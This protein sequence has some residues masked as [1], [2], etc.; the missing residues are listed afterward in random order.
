MR[1]GEVSPRSSLW[2]S[3]RFSLRSSCSAYRGRAGAC[4]TARGSCRVWCARV[5]EED[6]DR[7]AV[8][9]ALRDVGAVRFDRSRRKKELFGDLAVLQALTDQIEDL[10]LEGL[11]GMWR[12]R[13]LQTSRR[14]ASRAALIFTRRSSGSTGFSMKEIAPFSMASTAVRIVPWPES[15][16]TA[17]GAVEI[18]KAL[19]NLDAAHAGHGQVDDEA[20]GLVRFDEVEEVFAAGV[21]ACIDAVRRKSKA[22]R[23]ADLVVVD[24]PD[25]DFLL[26]QVF[27]HGLLFGTISDGHISINIA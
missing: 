15:T 11:A 16:M 6:A 2:P 19:Q 9:K 17:D 10:C 4:R 27:L 24:D 21:G 14:E 23:I 12:T 3:S 1:Q 18:A 7:R 25:G 8:F 26:R 20:A 5:R 22:D 13:V